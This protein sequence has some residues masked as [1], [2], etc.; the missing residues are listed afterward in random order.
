[1]LNLQ[2]DDKVAL[3]TGAGQGVG[4][5]IAI[6]LAAQGCKVGVNDLFPDRAEAVATEIRAAGHLAIPLTAD[7]CE[8]QSVGDMFHRLLDGFGPCDILVNNAGVPPTLREPGAKRPN[9]AET[10]VHEQHA[11]IALNV[12]GT[13]YCCREALRQM[14]GRRG[15]IV[16]IV[17]EAGRRGEARLAAYSGAKAAIVGFTMALAREYSPLGITANC[18]ALGAVVHE[19]IRSGPLSS[20]SGPELAETRARIFRTYPAAPG[21]GRLGTPEDVSAAVLF[22]SSPLAAFITGQ[23]LGVSGGYHMQ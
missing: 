10:T 8:P 19:G 20:N 18:I 17:S 5:R 14:D 6:E 11:Q 7:I 9:F 15:R 3:V 2:L 4:R 16:S 13:M 23:T 12:N 22:L 21:L 1:M